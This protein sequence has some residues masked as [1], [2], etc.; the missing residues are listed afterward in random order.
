MFTNYRVN[1]FKSNIPPYC[2]F[3]SGPQNLNPSLEKVAHLFYDCIFSKNLW[4]K[5][6]SWLRGQNIH[7]P[8]DRVVIL[9]GFHEQP[10]NSVTNYIIL[11]VKYFIWKSKFKSQELHFNSFLQFL[12]GKL[13]DLKNAYLYEGKDQKFEQFDPVYSSLLR[14]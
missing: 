3:C 10:I 9:F 2:N 13:D 12:R 4:I 1:K 11:C 14:L 6:E 7:I 8:L 5:V